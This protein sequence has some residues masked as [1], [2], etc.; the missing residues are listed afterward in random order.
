[1]SGFHLVPA[2]RAPSCLL[3]PPTVVPDV[4]KEASILM[5]VYCCVLSLHQ[6][7]LLCLPHPAWC[8]L[9]VGSHTKSRV[10]GFN[11][12]LLTTEGLKARTFETP[13]GSLGIDLE[14]V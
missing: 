11:P 12:E 2:A 14:N 6:L 7:L 9:M 8:A 5:G 4:E 1:M 13:E 10:R 3:F